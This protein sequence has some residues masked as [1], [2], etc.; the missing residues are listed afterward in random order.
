MEDL[1]EKI[2]I[3]EENEF[4]RNNKQI[5]L[6]EAKRLEFV[7][8][9]SIDKLKNMTIDEYVMGKDSHD[10]FCYWLDQ[11]LDEVG[12]IRGVFSTKFDIF[13]SPSKKDYQIYR[14]NRFGDNLENAF[15]NLKTEIISLINAGKKQDIASL[16]RNILHS[17]LK[18]KILSIYYPNE[19]LPIFSNDRLNQF[20]KNL[21]IYN[22]S[23][24]KLDPIEKRFELIKFKN[25]N[26]L[27]KKWSLNE[28][29]GFLFYNFNNNGKWDKILTRLEK[30]QE[31]LP[32]S[33][34]AQ[35]KK[36][37]YVGAPMDFK[38]LR[39]EP[40]NEQGVVFLFGKM[41]EELGI[42]VEAVKTG[43]PD[44]EGKRL[45]DKNRNLWESVLIEFEYSS[46]N[47][48][49]HGHNPEECDLI[50]CWKHDWVDCPLEVIE[51]K[52]EILKT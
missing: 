34:I 46:K 4:E 29:E 26:E 2:R 43:F 48:L 15:H 50:I 41:H 13:Y 9:F 10:S 23:I 40:I 5:T 17:F 36:K 16:K 1:K 6:F 38:G 7:E 31:T 25:N 45:I 33:P 37:A 19:H 20:L 44:C 3:Y 21:G 42:I 18:G 49:A 30:N 35:K 28:F 39:H 8:K 14:K 22:S 51:L 52:S 27:M 24:N 32:S 11:K 47:F 12:N